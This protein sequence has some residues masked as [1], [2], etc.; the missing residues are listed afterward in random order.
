[1]DDEAHE[2]A[3]DWLDDE[4]ASVPDPEAEKPEIG[5]MKKMA[6]GFLPPFPIP[7]VTSFWLRQVGASDE[8]EPG[9]QGKWTAEFI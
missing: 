9:I 4:P 2:G 8:E 1:L 5:M 6:T 3:D 7:N